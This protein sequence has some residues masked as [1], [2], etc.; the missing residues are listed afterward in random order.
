MLSW[1][2]YERT[3][4]S[5]TNLFSF[6]S[7]LL[8]TTVTLGSF[9]AT[10]VLRKAFRAEISSDIPLLNLTS[11]IVQTL[12]SGPQESVQQLLASAD[13]KTHIGAAMA[14]LQNLGLAR[15][16]RR[17]RNKIIVSTIMA[18]QRGYAEGLVWMKI[19]IRADIFNNMLEDYKHS[20]S[21][22]E[23]TVDMMSD[24]VEATMILVRQIRAKVLSPIKRCT[25]K[26]RKENTK[27]VK[28][29]FLIK[30]LVQI[31]I[32]HLDLIKEVGLI[33]YVCSDS[34][35]KLKEIPCVSQRVQ[36]VAMKLN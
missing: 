20:N 35:N 19:L 28:W 16:V 5:S 13:I 6:F 11:N 1:V 29:M 27:N 22:M 7:G 25:A 26:C 23:K 8:L 12:A 9:V 24:L 10:L 34:H 14:L 3:W 4:C 18:Q 33:T 21:T 32:H 15:E 30:R 17:A 2:R 36:I 31:I